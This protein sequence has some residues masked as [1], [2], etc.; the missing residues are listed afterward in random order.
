M[1]CIELLSGYLCHQFPW[2]KSCRMRYEPAQKTVYVY[3][4]HPQDPENLLS[5][6]DAIARLDIGVERFIIT[7]PTV[8]DVVIE[9]QPNQ[10]KESQ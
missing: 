2:W 4:H 10:Y 9:C 8:M 3:C 7:M 1:S 5:A 6:G